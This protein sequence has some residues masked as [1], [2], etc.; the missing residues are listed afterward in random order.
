MS[1][2]LLASNL[3]AVDRITP[4]G[5]SWLFKPDLSVSDSRGGQKA[6]FQSA[7]FTQQKLLYGCRKETFTLKVTR[8]VSGQMETDFFVNT[9]GFKS[10]KGRGRE[11]NK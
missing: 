11:R 4:N 7:V 10:V 2:E 6:W 1:R 9:V 3:P 8:P 5:I